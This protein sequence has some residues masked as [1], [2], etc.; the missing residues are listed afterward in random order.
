M[1]LLD[2]SGSVT[3]Q[4]W[5]LTLDVDYVIEDDEVTIDYVTVEGVSIGEMLDCLNCQDGE[6]AYKH[7]A[8]V[9]RKALEGQ[10]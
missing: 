7:L 10:Q 1:K 9:V 6:P 2:H 4:C 8:V 3:V 5:G